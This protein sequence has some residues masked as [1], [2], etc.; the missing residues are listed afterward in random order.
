MKS[1]LA[2]DSPAA[3]GAVP[4]FHDESATVRS[5]FEQ[6]VAPS[7]TPAADPSHE[8][9]T[10]T[11]AAEVSADNNQDVPAVA[12]Q[13]SEQQSSEA[14]EPGVVQEPAQEL[15]VRG[16]SF[17]PV[18]VKDANEPSS[19]EVPAA[20]PEASAADPE[21]PAADPKAPAADPEAPVADPE[22][23]A[24]NSE[25]SAADSEAPAADSGVPAAAPELPAATKE[26]PAATPEVSADPETPA[27]AP[28]APAAAPEAPATAVPKVSAD[29]EDQ[30]KPA[31]ES[32]AVTGKKLLFFTKNV[33][34]GFGFVVLVFGCQI[35]TF[36]PETKLVS[37]EQ[38]LFEAKNWCFVTLRL[39]C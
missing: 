4:A 31:V 24:A 3:I 32:S 19:A 10:S 33:L 2:T 38:R 17:D 5:S 11:A 18:V 27:A 36:K 14:G 8:K 34:S 30:N 12:V 7:G 21:A 25:A 16:P 29:Q 28:E 39:W 37:P 1:A 20:T 22:A 13:Q 35:W 9:V 26:T 6:T 15:A 23:P